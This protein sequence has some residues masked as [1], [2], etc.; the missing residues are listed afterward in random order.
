[1]NPIVL[2]KWEKKGYQHRLMT[3]GLRIWLEYRS[4][5]H[6][7]PEWFVDNDTDLID[8]WLIDF[9]DNAPNKGFPD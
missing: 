1:M 7:A 2:E 4:R 3:D 8:Y 9:N 5:F 6:V